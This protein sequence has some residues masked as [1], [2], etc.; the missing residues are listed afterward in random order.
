MKIVVAFVLAAGGENSIK[1]WALEITRRLADALCEST[2][3]YLHK[4]GDN[5]LLT[6]RDDTRM[7]IISSHLQAIQEGR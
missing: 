4:Y 7:W 1:G 6:S 5:F 2:S 3:R